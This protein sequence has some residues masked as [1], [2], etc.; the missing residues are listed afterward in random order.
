M[1]FDWLKT[2]L[3]FPTE[4]VGIITRAI[5]SKFEEPSIEKK[6]VF[7]IEKKI[8][9]RRSEETYD[10]LK[11]YLSLKTKRITGGIASAIGEAQITKD[12]ATIGR[13][14]PPTRT[15]FEAIKEITKPVKEKIVDIGRV[16]PETKTPFEA[17]RAMTIKPV[18]EYL[19]PKP[20]TD[21]PAL[22]FYDKLQDIKK[23]PEQLVPFVAS[24]AEAINFGKLLTAAN[25]LKEDDA[26]KE[27]VSLL[28]EYVDHNSRDTSY[29]YKVL[30]VVSMMPSFMGELL[31]TSGIATAGRTATMKGAKETLKFL[32]TKKERTY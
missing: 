23:R 6:D 11:N 28:Q 13:T 18:K 8:P 21:L 17:I 31:A 7:E 1:P 27:D 15:P 19:K 20:P 22:D 16:L 29:G 9:D 14:L 30:D 12:I 10:Y 5:K 4:D 25:R 3:K 32:L 26:S 2:K 24:G